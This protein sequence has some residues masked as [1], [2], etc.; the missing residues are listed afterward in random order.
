MPRP[1]PAQLASSGIVPN[2]NADPEDL[3]GVLVSATNPDGSTFT[4]PT[5]A[6]PQGASWSAEAVS[7]ANTAGSVSRAASPGV[8]HYLS[9]F[10]VSFSAAPAAPV[11]IT[12]ESPAGT[13]LLRKMIASGDG[14]TFAFPIPIQAPTGQAV[15]ITVAAAGVAVS[16]HL[17]MQGFDL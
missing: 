11:L 16:S 15:T 2:V 10:Q 4:L 12:V 3:L 6:V 14:V 1:T 13:V 17:S 9:S 8:T 5:S 7:A